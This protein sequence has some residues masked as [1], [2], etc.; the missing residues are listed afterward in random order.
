MK[1]KNGTF[2]SRK[3]SIF[4]FYSLEN[5]TERS[6]GSAFS[7]TL[8]IVKS[9]SCS[10]KDRALGTVGGTLGAER[11]ASLIEGES[12]TWAGPCRGPGNSVSVHMI[13]TQGIQQ[14]GLLL[15][16]REGP[17]RDRVLSLEW[18]WTPCTPFQLKLWTS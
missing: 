18:D 3:K 14:E 5:K 1:D 6:T 2:V 4:N 11:R 15:T 12:R 7:S 17:C 13:G 8:H 9:V 10:A 16:L